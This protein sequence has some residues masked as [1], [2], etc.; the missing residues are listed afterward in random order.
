VCTCPS[1][2]PHSKQRRQGWS[3]RVP[4]PVV[5][6]S[7][8]LHQPCPVVVFQCTATDTIHQAV[9]VVACTRHTCHQSCAQ[10][11]SLRYCNVVFAG[12]PARDI[13]RQQS[14]LKAAVRL[15]S[16][17][18]SRHFTPLL[19]DR[20]WLPIRQRV[21]CNICTLVYCCLYGE[22]QSYLAELVVPISIAS[23]RAGLSSAQSLSI[24]VPRT[25]STLGDRAFS[26]A[27]PRALEQPSTAHKTYLLHGCLLKE[28]EIFS[29]FTSILTVVFFSVS[30]VLCFYS[31]VR[32]PCVFVSFTSP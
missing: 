27:A 5:E 11:V 31:A 12:L 13:Q 24:A 7:W 29:V 32:R 17:S 22:A 8:C 9:S 1:S 2:P 14:V 18:L 4:S 15:V 26:V 25:H 28:L 23:N 21:Q 30:F 6:R 3:G 20:H 16:S 10:S 19:R